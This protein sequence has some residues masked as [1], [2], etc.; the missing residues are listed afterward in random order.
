MN[1]KYNLHVAHSLN[2]YIQQATIIKQIHL[3]R[4]LGWCKLYTNYSCS[5]SSLPTQLGKGPQNSSNRPLQQ[6]RISTTWNLF[7]SQKKDRK[8]FI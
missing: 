2:K 6:V 4:S 5:L 8:Y 1:P 7:R 3:T